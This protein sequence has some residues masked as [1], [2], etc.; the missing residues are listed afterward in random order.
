MSEQNRVAGNWMQTNPVDLVG[1]EI[2]I[3]DRV[4]RAYTSGYA[5]NIEIVSVTRIEAEKV[6]LDNS[7]RAINFPG[8]LLV[9]TDLNI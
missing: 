2:K 4:A 7:K 6:Y 1:R 8:R 3:G 5:S 9:V